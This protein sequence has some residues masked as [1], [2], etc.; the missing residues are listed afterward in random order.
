MKW[1]SALLRTAITGTQRFQVSSM[2]TYKGVHMPKTSVLMFVI[3]ILIMVHFSHAAIEVYSYPENIVSGNSSLVKRSDK[4]EVSVSQGG[5]T[6]NCYVMYDKN[7]D[8][9]GNLASNPDN[10]WTNFSVSGGDVLVSVRRIDGSAMTKA[11]VFPKQKGIVTSIQN[12]T[13]SFSIPAGMS[14]LQLWV[15][16]NGLEKH[17]L[18]IF[19]DPA[20][21]DVPDM[22]G[23]DVTVI[24]TSDDISTVRSKLNDNKTYAY[25]EPGIHKWNGGTGQNYEG[26]KM[27]I[28]TNKKIYIPGGAYVIGSFSADVGGGWKVYGRGVISG[29]GLDKLGSATYIPWSAVYSGSSSYK[30]QRVEGIVSMCPPHFALTIRGGVDID[31]V[32]MFSW[33]HSTDGTITG[34]NSTVNNSFFKVMDDNIKV[35][36]DDCSHDNNTMYQQVNGAPFQFSWS[37]QS[38]QN[39]V[40]TNTY[41]INSIYKNLTGESNTAVINVV[42]YDGGD[43]TSNHLF[44]GIFI[45]NGVHRLLGLKPGSGTYRDFT[46]RNVYL[47]K[48]NKADPQKLWSYLKSATFQN[49]SICNFY[50]EGKL[51]DKV[52]TTGDNPSN[53]SWWF[54]G[55]S[56][57]ITFCQD[58]N[59]PPVVEPPVIEPPIVDPPIIDPPQPQPEDLSDLNLNAETCSAVNLSWSDTEG[60]DAYRIRRKQSEE[61]SYT[62]I[63]DTDADATSFTDESVA[64]GIT[65]IYQVRPMVNGVAVAISNTPEIRVPN[66]DVPVNTM[67][68]NIGN[69]IWIEYAGKQIRFSHALQWRL[70]DPSGRMKAQGFSEKISLGEFSGNYYYLEVQD[71]ILPLNL[72]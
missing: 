53:G 28:K 18:F 19:T 21:S 20:E 51:I 55:E 62:T 34:N 12:N 23:A 9:N 1:F 60:E 63:S 16:V 29:A 41:I 11:E 25:F 32:K 15:D 64:E 49:F 65:Y 14:K 17:P 27:P 47:N 59:Q 40:S 43:V 24:R 72:K 26:Y 66:C 46:I 48:G 33:W 39:T 71:R 10:H 54:Q 4:Y 42:N 70:Y 50:M 30:N 57:P 68:K 2:Q 5:I 8:M 44:D 67:E 58:N 6:K 22:N 37:G 56:G 45:D 13:A 61:G 31:N 7:Q 38:A 69:G 35:Y 52:N 3:G 36:G